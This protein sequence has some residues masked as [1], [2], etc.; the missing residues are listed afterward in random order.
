MK[1]VIKK[2]FAGK[3]KVNIN[4]PCF[5]VLSGVLLSSNVEQERLDLENFLYNLSP[6]FNGSGYIICD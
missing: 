1:A 3:K 2:I 4:K 6:D 5:A